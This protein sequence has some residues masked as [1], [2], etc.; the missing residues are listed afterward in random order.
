MHL[1]KS[2]PQDRLLHRKPTRAVLV[3]Y[4]P[5]LAASALAVVVTVVPATASAAPARPASVATPAATVSGAPQHALVLKCV[6]LPPRK[7]LF[8][9]GLPSF[10]A[11]LASGAALGVTG[12]ALKKYADH[13]R[14][15]ATL[16]GHRPPG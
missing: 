5:R 8:D 13:R 3:R 16:P 4:A 15:R 14:R 11:S 2:P 10:V 1:R 7:D 9:A 6:E 12:W